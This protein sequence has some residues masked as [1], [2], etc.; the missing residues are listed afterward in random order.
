MNVLVLNCGSS[1]VRF[2]VIDPDLDALERDEDR[3]L[4]SGRV[5]R[6]GVTP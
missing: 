5:E 6:V 4:A 2:Q 1:S 3:R